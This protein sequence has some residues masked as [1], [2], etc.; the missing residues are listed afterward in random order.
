MFIKLSNR[1]AAILNI[2]VFPSWGETLQF[3]QLCLGLFI[4]LI[5]ICGLSSPG[6]T[7]D[8]TGVDANP[9]SFDIPSEPLAAALQT[10]S[11]STGVELFYESEIT[12]G[13]RSPVL[14]G[15]FT[16]RAALRALLADTGFLIHYN[17]DDAV[18]LS[19]PG[20]PDLPRTGLAGATSLSLPQLDVMPAGE[21]VDET[22]LRQFSEAV[23]EDV[24]AALSKNSNIRSGTYRV[25]VKLWVDPSRTIRRADLA[26]TTGDLGRDA[27]IATAL[28]GLTISRAP[29]ANMPQ[30]VRIVISVGSP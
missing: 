8:G 14:K 25:H 6:S 27:E 19:L 30:P 13:L 2:F 5:M 16:P 26:Q 11:Q 21:A 18:S 10:Y 9:R 7:A 28:Q 22:Q 23:Q 24:T 20:D 4:C 17:R 1:D 15:R 12:V 3:D 29:P